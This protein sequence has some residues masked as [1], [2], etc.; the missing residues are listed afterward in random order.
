[1]YD[2][3][4]RPRRTIAEVLLEFK[5]A[6]I[7]LEYIADVFPEIRPR[8]FSIASS[9]KV[10]SRRV[11]LLV[12]IVKY[13]TILKLPRKGVATSWLATLQPGHKVAVDFVKGTLR[14]PEDHATPVICIGPGT[15]IA[16]FRSLINERLSSHPESKNNV[17]FFG[18]RSAKKD[19]YFAD[20]WITLQ[21]KGDVKLVLAASRDQED[22]IYVQHRIK[23]EA[24]LLWE[25][26]GQR[27][28]VVYI[29]G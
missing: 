23:D 26:I 5:S 13:K 29:S 9:S 22:K 28:G 12:A 25:Y 3:S 20:E 6:Q 18:C 4:N 2:Y 15:G 8:Q 19:F 27:S 10:N 11:E 16:P 21:A 24:E 1:M 17:I 14:L 7:P